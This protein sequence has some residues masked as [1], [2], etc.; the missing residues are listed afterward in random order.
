[1]CTKGLSTTK[2]ICLSGCERTLLHRC[3]FILKLSSGLVYLMNHSALIETFDRAD[4]AINQFER[5]LLAGELPPLEPLVRES[6]S[7]V[8][9]M[10]VAY[11]RDVGEIEPPAEQDDLLESFKILVKGDPSWNTIRDNCRE[12]VFYQNCL[13]MDRQDALPVKPEAMA[14]RTVRHVYLFMRSRA[15]R[16]NRLEMV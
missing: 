12:L 4:V 3:N 11:I 16:E 13:L 6:M 10:I 14:V 8:K 5:V 9:G 15:E 7:L 2:W 1:M